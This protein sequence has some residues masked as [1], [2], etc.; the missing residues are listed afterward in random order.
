MET[1]FEV[2]TRPNFQLLLA[3]VFTLP[4]VFLSEHVNSAVILRYCKWRNGL[5]TVA[6]K[7]AR[8]WTWRNVAIHAATYL[9][10]RPHLTLAQQDKCSVVVHL[11]RCLFL[12]TFRFG[13]C[14]LRRFRKIAKKRLLAPSCLSVR[15]HGTTRLTMD[16][17]SWNLIFEYF[18]ENLSR[19]F[20]FH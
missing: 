18:F 11:H 17:F 10:L 5:C 3:Y 16:G 13:I 14:F 2:G 1:V 7:M 12:A 6:G 20:D 19:K 8:T 4:L 15:P 9:A